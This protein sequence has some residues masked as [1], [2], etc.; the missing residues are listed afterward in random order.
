MD[1]DG[2]RRLSRWEMYRW[3][4]RDHL[5]DF[6]RPQCFGGGAARL[7]QPPATD[8][9]VPDRRLLGGVVVNCGALARTG[10]AIEDVVDLHAGLARP[11]PVVTLFLTEAMGE[12]APDAV[13]AE[14]VGP[15]AI[16]GPPVAVSRTRIVLN[17]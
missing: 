14:I 16:K 2:D 6:G 10:R 9:R 8:P 17:E 3:E 4:T 13:Y 15:A 7:P 1:L 12:L 5:P 11:D